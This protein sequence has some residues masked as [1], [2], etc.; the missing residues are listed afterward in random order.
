MISGVEDAR[1]AVRQAFYDGAD[2]IKVIVNTGPRVVS[3]DEMKTIVEE[4]QP[5]ASHRGRARDG[6]VATRIAAEAGVT[7]SSTRTRSPTTH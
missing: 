7:R 2:L 1:R 3:L 6:D 4:A 5:R